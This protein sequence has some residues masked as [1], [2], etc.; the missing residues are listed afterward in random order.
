MSIH[1]GME[2]RSNCYLL[3]FILYL[4][5]FS[6]HKSRF[7]LFDPN[8][9]RGPRR[10]GGMVACERG[11]WLLSPRERETGME[12]EPGEIRCRRRQRVS[13]F[14][15]IWLYSG[16]DVNG[17][18]FG[19]SSFVCSRWAEPAEPII[20]SVTFFLW[21]WK[22]TQNLWEFHF[23]Y[24]CIKWTITTLKVTYNSY[25]MSLR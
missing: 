20:I 8:T 2:H 24:D 22:K 10:G 14:D 4:L 18:G 5:N 15:L 11:Y 12:S 23:D 25:V 13:R 6:H 3:L 1:F 9:K 16:D 19:V 21:S 17:I 7:V